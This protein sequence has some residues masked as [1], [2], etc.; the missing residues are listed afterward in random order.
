[1]KRILLSLTLTLAGYSA[2][3]Q[4][5]GSL[6]NTFDNG[7]GTNN[8]VE[9]IT[10][11]PDGK[12]VLTGA[13]DS[14]NG[15][16]V[17]QV[18][19]L[20]SDGSLDNTLTSTV[21]GQT[22]ALALQ[23][24]GK[25][26]VG[27]SITQINGSAAR[28]V[29]RLNSD[30]SLDNT[31]STGNGSFSGTI[32]DI[33]ILFDGSIVIGGSFNLF[34]GLSVGNILKL[35][36]DGS[37]AVGTI[38]TNG[39][40]SDILVQPD[41]KM[42][43]CGGFTQYNGTMVNRIARINQDLTLDLSFDSGSGADDGDVYSIALQAD[44]KIILTGLFS[45]FNGVSKKLMVRLNPDGSL[46]NTF[47]IGNWNSGE[48][49][50]SSI[51]DNNKIAVGG[52]WATFNGTPMNSLLVFNNDGTIDNS[53]DIGTG[54]DNWVNDIAVQNDGK[55]IIGGDFTSYDGTNRNRITR[56]IGESS[57]SLSHVDTFGK[58]QL[59]PNPT[60]SIIKVSIVEPTSAFITS[61]NGSILSTHELN[62]ETSIDV[63]TYAPGIYF[64]RTAEGQTVK[65]IKE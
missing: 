52:N 37:I 51:L 64:I 63:S 2:Y 40:V 12:I 47:D 58:I 7:S 49:I 17:G 21:T 45:T 6:D 34:N 46:D 50:A 48:F 5:F 19:R 57:S 42:L 24:D 4:S 36:S 43:V 3:A 23:N 41:G 28:R 53:F 13:F 30:G 8:V 38:G 61:A 44:G 32:S 16:G 27:G 59:Q 11:Q 15:I 35:N 18:I 20:N 33:E 31:F 39:Y 56:L 60:N 62:G 29:A 54:P 55:I 9:A 10:L 65:F 22:K 1:M 25:I 14:Y 26:I